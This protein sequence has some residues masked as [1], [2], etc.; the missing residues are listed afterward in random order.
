MT[1]GGGQRILHEILRMDGVW[2]ACGS[3]ILR[4]CGA[5]LAHIGPR[6]AAVTIRRRYY[7]LQALALV[8]LRVI[9]MCWMLVAAVR[10]LFVMLR[11]MLLMMLTCSS[12]GGVR[13]NAHVHPCIRGI[14]RSYVSVVISGPGDR[15]TAEAC[16]DAH[17]E[18]LTLIQGKV[19]VQVM[20]VVSRFRR[21]INASWLSV[22]NRVFHKGVHVVHADSKHQ[23]IGKMSR[24]VISK[25]HDRG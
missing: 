1:V 11:R 9:V 5:C 17:G 6:V 16:L 18:S 25:K 23:G 13:P 7:T 22:T 12:A 4:V 24:L 14:T 3:N 2:C 15:R 8:K 10:M 20:M 21:R 19:M